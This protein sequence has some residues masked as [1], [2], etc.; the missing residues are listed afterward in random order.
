MNLANR[1]QLYSAA[2][3]ATTQQEA[4]AHL[5]SCIQCSLDE[6]THG[7][8]EAERLERHNLLR[9]AGAMGSP[10]QQRRVFQLY[11]GDGSNSATT[12]EAVYDN[13]LS[14]L[15]AEII[16]VCQDHK[17]AMLCHFAIGDSARPDL[18]ATT[19]LIGG[20]FEAPPGLRKAAIALLV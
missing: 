17:I 14:T 2:I 10:E 11:G 13:Q 5:E 19:A 6:G 9:Y 7:R 20:E 16:R 18:A 1:Q 12:K 4:D 3:N 15:M 8:Q